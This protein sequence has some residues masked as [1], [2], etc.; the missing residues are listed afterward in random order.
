MDAFFRN[1]A[2]VPEAAARGMTF[3]AATWHATRE[4]VR[5]IERACS[6]PVAP[7]PADLAVLAAEI[8]RQA[9]EIEGDMPFEVEMFVRKY[10]TTYG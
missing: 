8:R 1:H 9:P 10:R 6:P 7:N 4:L 5:E 2:T 3:E